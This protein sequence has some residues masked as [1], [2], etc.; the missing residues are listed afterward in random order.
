MEAQPIKPLPIY[1]VILSVAILCALGG[2]QIYR[3]NWKNNLIQQIDQKIYAP[4]TDLPTDFNK[5]SV[6]TYNLVK[7]K[8]NYLHDKEMYLYA[9]SRVYKGEPGYLVLTPFKREDGSYI[10]VN[11]GWVSE[12]NKKPQARPSSMVKDEVEIEGYLLEG[13]KRT[14]LTPDNDLIRNIWFWIDIKTISEHTKL[15]LPNYVVMRK[16]QSKNEVPLGKEIITANI[17]NDHFA[18]AV[19]WFSTAISVIVIYIISLRSKRGQ[20]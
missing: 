15:D 11:R 20:R 14:W 18:Y 10:L 4:V 9:G 8:G 16:M 6:L 3:L 7:I 13:E 19:I 5:F 12:K 17:R 2:W 1:F